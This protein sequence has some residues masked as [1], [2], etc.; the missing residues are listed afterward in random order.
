MAAQ[1]TILAEFYIIYR[2][3]H[4]NVWLRHVF[5]TYSEYIPRPVVSKSPA[6]ISVLVSDLLFDRDF[7]FNSLDFHWL[8]INV[9]EASNPEPVALR[10]FSIVKSAIVDE[11]TAVNVQTVHHKN[12]V[13]DVWAV[14]FHY[15]MTRVSLY[16]RNGK[17]TKY[18]FRSLNFNKVLHGIHEDSCSNTAFSKWL[19]LNVPT[20]NGDLHLDR[21]VFEQP[22]NHTGA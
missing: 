9:C 5:H 20:R 15:Q 6:S 12:P 10:D 22:R 1:N 21:D 7:I 16:K 14:C 4:N 17:Y 11:H 2:R 3:L 13:T 8:R 19:Y 18:T